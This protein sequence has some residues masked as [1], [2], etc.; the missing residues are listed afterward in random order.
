MNN[1][2]KTGLFKENL[3]M[4]VVVVMVILAVIVV[5]AVL[6]VVAVEL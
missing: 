1:S 5:V 4:V 6:I 3:N 2:W